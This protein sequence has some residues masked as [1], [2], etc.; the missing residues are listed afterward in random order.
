MILTLL[1]YNANPLCKPTPTAV[2]SLEALINAGA[3]V[4]AQNHIA[5][6]TPLHCAI[7]GTFQSFKETHPRRV[8]CAKLLLAAGA[9]A[10]LRD[11]RGQDALGCVDDTVREALAKNTGDDISGDMREMRVALEGAGVNASPLGACIEAMDAGGARRLVG[12]GEGGAAQEVTREQLTKGILQ[13]AE[14]FKVLLDDDST[15]ADAFQA[16]SAIM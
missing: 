5:E 10:R 4:D 7:R 9:D 15:D 12:G 11:K 14:K 13:A 6:M 2:E 8:L 3:N 16:L 1:P